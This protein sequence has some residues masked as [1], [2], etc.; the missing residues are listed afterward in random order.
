MKFVFHPL[1]LGLGIAAAIFGLLPVYLICALTALL[2][3]C[4]HIFYAARLGF[5]CKKISLMPYGASAVCDT[6]GIRAKDEIFLALSGPAV[7]VFICIF[8]A[9]LWWFFPVTY[10]YTDTVFT[11]SAAM[12]AVNLLPAYPLDGG[13]AVVSLFGM[14]LPKK[15]V[16]IAL[17]I[18]S[19]A[20]CIACV[21]IFVFVLRNI[22]LLIFACFLLFSAFTKDG[23]FEKIDYRSK[24]IARGREIRH[25]MLN[26]NSTYK[27]ALRFVNEGKYCIFNF[28]SDGMLDEICEE[29]LFEMLQNHSIYDKINE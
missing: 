12:L 24:K 3:E 17:R 4:G 28:F 13:R 1:F 9:G 22:T 16:K 8:C 21:L 7:N 26:E 6:E 25:V 20:V 11:A 10:A 14:F 15:K 23:V 19:G 2:H 29:E 18:L 27:D 5:K